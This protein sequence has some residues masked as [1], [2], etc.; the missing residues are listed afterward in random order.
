MGLFLYASFVQFNQFT[1]LTAVLLDMDGGGGVW[2][3]HVADV[4]TTDILVL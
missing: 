2:A 3:A 1:N 4:L